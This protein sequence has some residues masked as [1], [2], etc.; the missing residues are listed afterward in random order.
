MLIKKQ[1]KNLLKLKVNILSNLVVVVN[2]V[3]FGLKW[4][5]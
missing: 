3:M 5:H 4:N 1:F 2:M